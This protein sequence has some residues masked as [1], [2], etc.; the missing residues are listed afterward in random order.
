M[1]QDNL[2][3]IP[4]TTLAYLAGIMDADGC[5]AMYRY[6]RRNQGRS[7]IYTFVSI[8]QTQ[9]EAVTLL[10][11]TFGGKVRLVKASAK[12]GKPLFFWRLDS[13]KAALVALTLLPYLRLKKRQAEIVCAM[14]EEIHTQRHRQLGP[15]QDAQYSSGTRKVRR[16]MISDVSMERRLAFLH[17]IRQLNDSRYREIITST[18]PLLAAMER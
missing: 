14:Q 17:E 1:L 4:P 3:S 9:P 18:S 2:T 6:P 7:G 16:Y 8:K 13:Q 12:G 11:E 10:S 15:L 5:F